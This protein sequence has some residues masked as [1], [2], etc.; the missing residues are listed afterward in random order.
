PA[1]GRAERRAPRRLRGS[2]EARA[3]ARVYAPSTTV[4]A[5]GIP[6]RHSPRTRRRRTPFLRERTVT[7]D[8]DEY[9]QRFAQLAGSGVDVHGEAAFV[10]EYAPATL[11]DAGCGTGRVAVELIRRGVRVTGVDADQSM[12]ATARDR[13][14]D[15]E[16]IECDLTALDLGRV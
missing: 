14:P 4:A 13:A 5:R 1:H 12:L 10:M 3:H 6:A 8:G 9:Q 15:G 7:W 11:L 2:R 16:W